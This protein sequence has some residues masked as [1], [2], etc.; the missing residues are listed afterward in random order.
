MTKVLLFH[1][2]DP[3]VHHVGGIGTFIDTFIKH[4]PADVNVRMVGVTT[5]P[6]ARPVGRWQRLVVGGRD[7]DF[8][9]VVAAHPGRRGRVPISIHFTAGLMRHRR[10]IDLDGAVLGV[11]RVEPLAAFRGLRNPKVLVLHAH[12]KDL[13]NPMTEVLWRKAPWLYFQIERRLIRDLAQLY[14]VREDGAAW[15]K[16]EYPHLADRIAFLPTWVD[17]DTF[18]SWPEERRRRER[19]QLA[20]I[21]GFNP[22]ERLLL[23]IGR[24]EGQKDP[25]LLLQ[26]FQQ[27]TQ[28]NGAVG[29][30]RLVMIGEGSLE[31]QIREFLARQ[32]LADRVQLLAGRPQ[33]EIAQWMNAADC[34]CLSSAFEGMPRVVVEALG[35]GLPVVT[36]AVGESPRLLQDP[37]AGRLVH[38]RTPQAL[39]AGIA[40]LLAHAPDRAACLRQIQPFTA[41][42][43]LEGVYQ[44]YRELGAGRW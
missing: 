20:Q 19:E 31:G 8:L 12:S 4:A 22:S 11:H 9:P 1:Q 30:A 26:T 21:H 5:D 25:L 14:V 38:D 40:D 34:L 39:A 17:E 10:L 41:N 2:H 27:L 32:G 35:C 33:T 3:G 44:R 16:Q 29:P 18:A 24:F 42:K 36:T 37:G 13:K 23:F 28:M 15:Y 6:V 7:C 43:I